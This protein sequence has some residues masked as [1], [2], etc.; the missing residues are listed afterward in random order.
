MAKPVSKEVAK[1]IT[2]T[3][4]VEIVKQS[5]QS[6]DMRCVYAAAIHVDNKELEVLT[7][8]YKELEDGETY[9]FKA[10]SIAEGALP[11]KDASKPAGTMVDAVNLM[12]WDEASQSEKPCI[13]ADAVMVST[14]KRLAER[15]GGLPCMIKVYVEGEKKSAKGNYKDLKIFKF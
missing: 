8:E 9:I 14:V 11:S 7:S 4:F 1:Q 13:N 3:E 2:K 6:Q 12:E 15:D 10:V 5:A